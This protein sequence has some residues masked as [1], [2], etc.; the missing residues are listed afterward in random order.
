[1]DEQAVLTSSRLFAE[2]IARVSGKNIPLKSIS[3]KPQG[4]IILAGTV[5]KNRLI[6]Q[7]IKNKKINADSLK[8]QW[9]R[10]TIQLVNNPFP[11]VKKALVIAGSDRRGTAYG[12]FSISEAIGVSPWYWWAD[13]PVKKKNSLNLAV[14]NFTSKTPAVKYRGLFINDED[15][16]LLRWAKHT[17][18]PDLIDI[19][20][21]T[22]AKVFELLPRLKATCLCPT[23]HEASGAFNKYAE[24]KHVA[25]AFGILMG[26]VHPEPLLFN[27]ASEWDKKTMGPWDYMTNKENILKVLDKRVKEN[28]PFE[29]VYTVALR[30]LHDRAMEGNYSMEQRVK[31][32]EDAVQDQR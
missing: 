9:E 12:L 15:W 18:D 20:P 5:G 32:L 22:Y 29:N 8:G 27:N 19:G 28:S 2:D 31:L 13:V 11:N 21:K 6:D 3:S 17:F 26:S 23:M 30:G 14:I 4:S 24:N 7:L 10:Y 25:D 1:G 16:G